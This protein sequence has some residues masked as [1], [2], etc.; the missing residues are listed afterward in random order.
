MIIMITRRCVRLCVQETEQKSEQKLKME[1]LL[2]A[3]PALSSELVPWFGEPPEA[4][5]HSCWQ[6]L[7]VAELNAGTKQTRE[8][9][10]LGELGMQISG[11]CRLV[12]Q[13]WLLVSAV[14]I[15]L[16]TCFWA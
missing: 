14:R 13:A 4:P 6:P 12:A 7:D 16:L 1:K 9:L 8:W 11:K 3:H 10:G 15:L 5:S 2:R